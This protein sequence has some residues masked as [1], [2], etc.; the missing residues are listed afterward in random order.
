MAITAIIAAVAITAI[1]EIIVVVA[2]VVITIRMMT[3]AASITEDPE[4][5]EGESLDPARRMMA[6]A[7]CLLS[8]QILHTI[9]RKNVTAMIKKA[10]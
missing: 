3:A 7:A 10:D 8:G 2:T 5:V 1:M 4:E 6:H 9:M